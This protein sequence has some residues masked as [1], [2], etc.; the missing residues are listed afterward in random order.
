MNTRAAHLVLS[1][2][3]ISLA[4]EELINA[5]RRRKP[6]AR[7]GVWLL[8][9]ARTAVEIGLPLIKTAAVCAE[10][11]VVQLTEDRITLASAS[12]IDQPAG[13]LT[14]GKHIDLLEPALR[15]ALGACTIGAALEEQVA[16]LNASGETMLA[17]LLDAVGVMA[18]GKVG[19]ALR[20]QIERH[21]AALGWGVGPA[22]SPGSLAGWSLQGQ[23][24]LAALLD[25]AAV[26]ISLTPQCVLE[27][28]KS[29]TFVVGMGP[30]YEDHHI[31]SVCVLCALYDTCWRRREVVS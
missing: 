26:E 16:R 25:L 15:M 1:N 20:Q 24:D 18:L 3:S 22:L 13:A 21:A 8:E 29:V 30:R 12:R 10:Y 7:S 28:H 17:Y 23:R 2:I 5:Q 14:I 31:G 11:E 27:P 6:A 9:S 19:E 4:P